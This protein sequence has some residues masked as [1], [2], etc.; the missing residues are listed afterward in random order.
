MLVNTLNM[1]NKFIYRILLEIL[2][3]IKFRLM[4]SF[5]HSIFTDLLKPQNTTTK[6]FQLSQQQLPYKKNCLDNK[7]IHYKNY[8]LKN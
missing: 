7:I 5:K 8:I 6:N 4:I 1:K 3:S 2:M